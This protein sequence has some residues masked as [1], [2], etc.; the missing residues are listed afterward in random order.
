MW[1][2]SSSP[3]RRQVFCYGAYLYNQGEVRFYPSDKANGTHTVDVLTRIRAQYPK[4]PMTLIG[5]GASY[6]TSARVI[7]TAEPL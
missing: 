4:M 1:V 3:G 5:D 7:Q 2:S 6:Q